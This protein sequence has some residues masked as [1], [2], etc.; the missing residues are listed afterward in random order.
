VTLADGTALERYC[1][2]T[3]RPARI[4]GFCLSSWLL[5][6]S[7]CIVAAPKRS[8][9][10]HER[11]AGRV[12]EITISDANLSYKS[13]KFVEAKRVLKRTIGYTPDGNMT[14]EVNYDSHGLHNTVSTTSNTSFWYDA[15]GNRTDSV[16]FE[17]FG[18]QLFRF[19]RWRFKLD[20][21]DNRTEESAYSREADGP[22][23]GE[24]LIE[25]YVHTYDNQ[26]KRKTT[27]HFYH[28]VFDY[29]LVYTY[30]STGNVNEQSWYSQDGHLRLKESYTYEFDSIGNWVR[31]LTQREKTKHDKVNFEPVSVTYRAIVYY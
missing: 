22:I 1:K 11:L 12:K 24:I 4:H 9:R 15:K 19:I 7:V 2:L 21:D 13:G 20:A 25:R 16:Y 14:R 6:A 28:E 29:K 17:Q 5:L 3:R 27:E 10:E 23:E 18:N 26:N 8:E 30:D 31:K